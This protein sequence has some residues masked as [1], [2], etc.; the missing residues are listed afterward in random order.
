ML[1]F[2]LRR[3][4]HTKRQKEKEKK[5]RCKK[6]SV[7]LLLPSVTGVCSL[8]WS[9]SCRMLWVIGDASI[10]PHQLYISS[11]SFCLYSSS[12][13]H[14]DYTSNGSS[15]QQPPTVMELCL[16]EQ[17]CLPFSLLLSFFFSSPLLTHTPPPIF[18]YKRELNTTEAYR[19]EKKKDE[20]IAVEFSNLEYLSYVL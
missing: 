14:S 2:E 15:S 13:I 19:G 3:K 10:T 6:A 16:N 7:T 17:P 12:S 5:S 9:P 20:S 11:C 8:S 1:N 4:P 18:I